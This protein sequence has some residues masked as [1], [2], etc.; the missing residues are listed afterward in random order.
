[1]KKSIV[2]VS[3]LTYL[4]ISSCSVAYQRG[5]IIHEYPTVQD[6]FIPDDPRFQVL[7]GKDTVDAICISTSP[8]P[9]IG[10]TVEV[11]NTGGEYTIK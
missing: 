4:F 1:M 7:I 11:A 8:K 3:L 10:A 6:S 9:V 5:V 2:L